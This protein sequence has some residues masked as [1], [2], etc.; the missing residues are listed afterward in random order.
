MCERRVAVGEVC[1]WL[2]HVMESVMTSV[3]LEAL[4][5]QTE[6]Q[7]QLE[8]HTRGAIVAVQEWERRQM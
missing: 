3:E 6:T 7:E 2:C 8:K 4:I 5:L 1:L